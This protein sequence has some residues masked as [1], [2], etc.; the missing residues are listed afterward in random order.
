MVL[1]SSSCSCLDDLFPLISP[2]D[3][4]QRVCLSQNRHQLVL[5]HVLP[6]KA[7]EG[8]LSQHVLYGDAKAIPC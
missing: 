2:L 8:S 4:L 3:M 5:T 7:Y 6:L 1:M